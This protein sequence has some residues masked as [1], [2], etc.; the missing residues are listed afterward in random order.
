MPTP[1]TPGHCTKVHCS[2]EGFVFQPLLLCFH[3]AGIVGQSEVPASITSLFFFF[4]R[5][6]VM[7]G[8]LYFKLNFF[9]YSEPDRCKPRNVGLHSSGPPGAPV[10]PK[11]HCYEKAFCISSQ[12]LCNTVPHDKEVHCGVCVKYCVFSSAPTTAQS[13]IK[14]NAKTMSKITIKVLF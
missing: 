8:L 14:A 1:G 5:S 6:T 9:F 10:I 3:P 12:L 4:G 2:R 11:V 7:R 13:S